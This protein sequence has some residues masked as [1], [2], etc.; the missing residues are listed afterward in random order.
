MLGGGGLVDAYWDH[1][2]AKP[3][4]QMI[5]LWGGDKETLKKMIAPADPITYAGNLKK[6]DLLML[7]ASRLYRARQELC[8]GAEKK[9]T[10]IW[11]IPRQRAIAGAFAA[12]HLPFA[13]DAWR[14]TQ[15]AIDAINDVKLEGYLKG[16]LPGELL[17][18][19]FV[20]IVL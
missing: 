9:L 14:R 20:Q 5:A 7:A 11:D 10:G 16:V 2:Q 19:Y 17:N 6:R 15:A 13:D 3:Y 8:S 18:C 12:S 1:P 4:L